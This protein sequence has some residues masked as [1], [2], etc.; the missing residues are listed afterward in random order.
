MSFPRS[1]ERC[2]CPADCPRS[3]SLCFLFLSSAPLSCVPGPRNGLPPHPRFHLLVFPCRFP[4]STLLGSSSPCSRVLSVS[5]SAVVPSSFCV[6]L[7]LFIERLI[8]PGIKYQK[9][10]PLF[11]GSV[12]FSRSVVSD[13]LRPHE[14]QHARP[15]CP[16]PTP[17]IHPNSCAS[18]RWCHPAISSSAVPLS[19]SPLRNS[20]YRVVW[21]FPSFLLGMTMTEPEKK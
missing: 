14:L 6:Q 15:A 16:S 8:S 17:R 20:Y 3:P 11:S 2:S 13:S 1:A 18:S 19:S 7:P 10:L 21:S 4:R 12:Q 5:S 9:L